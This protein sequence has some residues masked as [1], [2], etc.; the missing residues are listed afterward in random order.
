MKQNKYGKDKRIRLDDVEWDGALYGI[1]KLLNLILPMERILNSR[2]FNR[3]S[4][5]VK[6]YNVCHAKE[7]SRAWRIACYLF[8]ECWCCSGIRGFIYGTVTT[9]IV[10]WI[11][12]IVV[13]LV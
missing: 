7:E 12:R 10:Y 8:P 3:L 6:K 4:I 13:W 1:V 11:V 5:I 2:W 9:I